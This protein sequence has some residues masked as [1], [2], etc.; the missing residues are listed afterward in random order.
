MRGK[1]LLAQGQA[2]EALSYFDAVYSEI[3]GEL[4]PKLA[5]ALA[6]ELTGDLDTAVRFY[7]LVSRVDPGYTTAAFGLARCLVRQQ[8]KKG[9][10]EAY[11]RVPKASISYTHA[12][13]GRVKMLLHPEPT[14]PGK[15]EFMQAA[16]ALRTIAMDNYVALKL[17]ADLMLSALKQVEAGA[18]PTDKNTRLLTVP[19]LEDNL[20]NSLESTL[21][22][23]ARFAQTEEDR[24]ELVDRANK[25][26]RVTWF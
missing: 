12:V 11:N 19:L 13:A 3:P 20:R 23:C 9:A 8:D 26:R 25:V 4:V 22:Q 10:V 17:Q 7:D 21:R 16:E 5:L 6:S 15:T 18:L 2:Q 1:Q 14:E 24:I